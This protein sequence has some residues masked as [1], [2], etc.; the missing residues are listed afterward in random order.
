MKRG[1]SMNDIPLWAQ[2]VI[3]ILGSGTIG[4]VAGA[5]SS[6]Y[7]SRQKIK[8]LELT[9]RQKLEENYR[10]NIASHLQALYIP[11]NTAISKLLNQH[12]RYEWSSRSNRKQAE[13][14][15]RLVC[16]QFIEQMLEIYDKGEDIYL[17]GEIDRRLSDL[18]FF[19][20]SSLDCSD[21]RQ[22]I[23][24]YLFNV[25]IIRIY[26]LI[27]KIL[28]IADFA[29]ISSHIF[30]ESLTYRALQV[31]DLLNKAALGNISM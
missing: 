1:V 12:N 17:S 30:G 18:T 27:P 4:G 31:K 11:I 5:F 26:W 29:P 19:I 15:F 28:L 20:K 2:I 13:A 22:S 25:R 3:G 9:Y 24:Y 23:R 10:S 14:D 7:A 21:N 16:E 6:S 8:E